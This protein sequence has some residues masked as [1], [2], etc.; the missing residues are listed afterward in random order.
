MLKIKENAP[1]FCGQN[2]DGNTFCIKDNLGYWVVLYFAT[3]DKNHVESLKLSNFVKHLTFFKENKIIIKAVIPAGIKALT[4]LVEKYDLDIEFISDLNHTIAYKYNV[5][6]NSKE[7]DKLHD[8]TFF[9]IGPQGKV[10][11]IYCDYERKGNLSD[12]INLAVKKLKL[13]IKS[14]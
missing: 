2:N 8:R 11:Y 7:K 6:Y 12:Y 3:P 1:D 9:I 10:R 14:K 13:L 5:D 4:N